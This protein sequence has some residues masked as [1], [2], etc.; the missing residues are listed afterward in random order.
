M[1]NRETCGHTRGQTINSSERD[2]QAAAALV[3]AG[4]LVAIADR[5]A[6]TIER[7]EVV[8]YI[9][10]R[11]LVPAIPGPGIA[12]LFDE[13]AHRLGQPDFANV[14]IEALRPASELHLSSEIVELAE[15]VAAA[16]RHVHSYE[17]QAVRLIRLITMSVPKFNVVT[18]APGSPRTE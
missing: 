14:A 4:A 15:R 10:D 18:S 3:T 7:E 6:D 2:R 9:N 1:P 8:R 11:Q 16:D 17:W 12:R 5:H 13:R